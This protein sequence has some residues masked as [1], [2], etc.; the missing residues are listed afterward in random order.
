MA[1]WPREGLYETQYLDDFFKKAVVYQDARLGAEE[2]VKWRLLREFGQLENDLITEADV[3]DAVRAN[4]INP[5][6]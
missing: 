2:I 1:E 5:L 4:V 3:A 6:M